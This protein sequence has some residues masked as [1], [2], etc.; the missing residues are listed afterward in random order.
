M[1]GIWAWGGAGT[2]AKMLAQNSIEV[3]RSQ[4]LLE[5]LGPLGVIEGVMRLTRLAL[6]E[7]EL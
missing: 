7:H 1:S 3:F 2:I 6:V 5:S 4:D